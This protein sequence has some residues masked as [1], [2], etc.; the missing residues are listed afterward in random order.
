MCKPL[1]S[2]WTNLR[3]RLVALRLPLQV[4]LEQPLRVHAILRSIFIDPMQF[5]LGTAFYEFDGPNDQREQ[6]S[7]IPILLF[8]RY[9]FRPRVTEMNKFLVDSGLNFLG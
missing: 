1:A 2:S 3:E 6:W 5:L 9:S 7:E 8:N 4:H